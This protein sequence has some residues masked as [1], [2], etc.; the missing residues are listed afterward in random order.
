MS[1][2]EQ[3]AE[4]WDDPAVADDGDD[5]DR[6]YHDR[7]AGNRCRWC[8][9]LL[10]DDLDDFVAQECFG[11]Q[12]RSDPSDVSGWA[13]L[14]VLVRRLQAWLRRVRPPRIPHGSD[15]LPF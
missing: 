6:W 5:A 1:H 10:L 7:A 2:H 13:A 9:D 14:W 15:D 3:T 8:G 12:H 11:C 4:A